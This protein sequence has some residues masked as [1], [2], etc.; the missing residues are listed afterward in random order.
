MKTDLMISVI[1]LVQAQQDWPLIDDDF[2]HPHLDPE[3]L[4][5]LNEP[6]F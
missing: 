3:E 4:N 6:P 5:D 2:P 1:E